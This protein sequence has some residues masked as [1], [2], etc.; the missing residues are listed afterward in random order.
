MFRSKEK[1]YIDNKCWDKS[2][3]CLV[4][5]TNVLCYI[6]SYILSVFLPQFK[7]HTTEEFLH[8]QLTFSM[9]DEVWIIF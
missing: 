5:K 6:L 2:L 4:K 8:V 3:H 1:F 9:I 7:L